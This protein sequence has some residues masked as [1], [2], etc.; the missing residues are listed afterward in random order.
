MATIFHV[1]GINQQTQFQDQ[2]G[3][4]TYLL[5]EGARPIQELI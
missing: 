3:R 5:P 1:L 4:P 2:S